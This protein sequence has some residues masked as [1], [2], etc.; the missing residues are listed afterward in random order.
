FGGGNSND[1]QNIGNDFG[2]ITSISCTNDNLFVLNTDG[3]LFQIDIVDLEKVIEVKTEEFLQPEDKFI[4]CAVGDKIKVGLTRFGYIYDFPNRLN[5]DVRSTVDIKVGGVHCLLL[6]S[7]GN[8]Y[9]FG[10]GSRGQLGLGTLEDHSNPTQ[11]EALAGIQIVAIACGTWHCAVI[12]KE[13]D[14]YTWGWN[15]NGQLGLPVHSIEKNEGV[16]VMASPHVIDFPD[17]NANAVKVACGKR[18]TIVL[19]DNG[20]IY[21]CGMNKYKQLKED[22]QD[23]IETMN[24]LGDF[25]RE[26]IKEIKCGPWNSVIC[27]E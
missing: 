18:H 20:E 11:I 13:G 3:Q 5:F 8:V 17:P 6:D 2:C 9:S 15:Q 25:S 26:K 22:D 24:I 12:S 10:N 16:S 4:L 1:V 14:V 21:G 27:C 7:Q 23:V 19:L